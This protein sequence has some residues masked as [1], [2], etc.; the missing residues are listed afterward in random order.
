MWSMPNHGPRMDGAITMNVRDWG[1]SE[2]A[3]YDITDLPLGVLFDELDA[4]QHALACADD[5][6]RVEAD[7]RLDSAIFDIIDLAVH[8]WL[9]DEEEFPPRRRLIVALVQQV[10][11]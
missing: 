7:D 9:H 11:A 4:A 5:E 10:L 1:L 3:F 6:H 8:P 2:A